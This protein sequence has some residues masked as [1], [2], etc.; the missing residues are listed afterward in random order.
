LLIA[1]D[2]AARR[3]DRT[4]RAIGVGCSLFFA[5]DMVAKRMAPVESDPVKTRAFQCVVGMALL[6]PQVILSWSL[7]VPSDLPFLLGLA[8]F[9]AIGHGL[10]IVAF[11]FADASTLAPLVYIELIGTYERVRALRGKESRTKDIPRRR[12]RAAWSRTHYGHSRQRP[13]RG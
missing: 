7:P 10:S 5:L 3:R 9:S 11:R 13:R 12:E 1:G 2:P 4:R 6:T 8:V